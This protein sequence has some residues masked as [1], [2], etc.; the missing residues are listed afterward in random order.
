MALSE[1]GYGRGAQ[2]VDWLMP[3]E[4]SNTVL[5]S[6]SNHAYS[7]LPNRRSKDLSDIQEPVE[8]CPDLDWEKIRFYA[9]HFGEWT[10]LEKLKRLS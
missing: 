6:F 4:F 9:D 10:T 1:Y 2:D 8:R 7:N 3:E 5:S